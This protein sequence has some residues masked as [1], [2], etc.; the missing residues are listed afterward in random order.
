M[1][2]IDFIV[3]SSSQLHWSLIYGTRHWWARHSN[4]CSK[5]DISERT[6]LPLQSR[7]A[8]H[9]ENLDTSG[10]C[11]LDQTLHFIKTNQ[12]M[13]LRVIKRDNYIPGIQY[14]FKLYN[15]GLLIKMSIKSNCNNCICNLLTGFLCEY[16]IL[17]IK[18]L[19]LNVNPNNARFDVFTV[20]S[21][22]WCGSTFHVTFSTTISSS[23]RIFLS[24]HTSEM[25][26]RIVT[27]LTV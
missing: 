3:Y 20:L 7:R 23:P 14:Q 16:W 2:S 6:A 5:P 1:L 11:W 9:V 10:W 8:S 12:F 4:S 22:G 27:E 19:I 24:P 13:Q 26:G 15:S 17:D 21:T 25:T 18:Y